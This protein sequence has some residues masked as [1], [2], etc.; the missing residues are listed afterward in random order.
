MPE[1]KTVQAEI[2]AY[3]SALFR[4][5]FGKGP[6]SV[7]VIIRN[8]YI[9]IHFRGFISPME[10]TLLKQNEWK[11][12]LETR[13]LLM[14]ELKPQIAQ[15]LLK[16]TKLDFPHMFVDWN[17]SKE[18]GMLLGLVNDKTAPEISQWPAGLDKG[19]FHVKLEQV[20]E[21]AQR[22]PGLIESI[23]LND[24]TL[25]VM[26]Q[27]I[28]IGIEQALISEGFSDVLKLTKRP[29]EK[30][31]LHK[32]SLEKTLK[33]SILE[34]FMDWDFDRDLGYIAFILEPTPHKR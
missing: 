16:I 21:L 6:S 28:L 23:W 31:L 11:R 18:S 24:R 5:H 12:V 33:R 32:A 29:L 27:E 1:E 8:P 7:F 3:I 26:R 14:T 4:K 2:S 10:R 34:I 25:L 17:L 22:K 20:N 19:E 15:E 9:F 30:D 13:D